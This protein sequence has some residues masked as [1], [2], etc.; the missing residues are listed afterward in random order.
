[1]KSCL[2]Y[3]LTDGQFFAMNLEREWD[4]IS[5]FPDLCKSG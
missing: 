2:G 1:M 4:C 3:G 5:K